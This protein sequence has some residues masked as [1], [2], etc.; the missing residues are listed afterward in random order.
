MKRFIN[1]LSLFYQVTPKFFCFLFLLL[2]GETQ[3]QTFTVKGN[4]T[5]T[6]STH[7]KY[8]YVT[9]VDQGDTTKKY[10]AITNTSGNYQLSVITNL[11]D[12]A[13]TLPQSFELMQNYPNPFSDETNIPYTLNEVSNASVTIYNILGQAVKSFK[14]LEQGGGMHGVIWDGRDEFGKKVSTGVYFY[15]LLARGETK[16]KKMIF[17]VG[18]GTNTKLTGEVFSYQGLKKETMGKAASGMFTVKIANT[19]ITQPKI[20]FSETS[21]V[22]LQQDTTLNFKIEKGIMAYH[23]C[24]KK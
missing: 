23:L 5:T 11:K 17:T 24:M 6:D 10:F 16:V 12:E 18:G 15:Q 20:L 14:Y 22:I 7:V 2:I 13:P 8:A 19:E 3:S 4:I 1:L 9:F 21:K